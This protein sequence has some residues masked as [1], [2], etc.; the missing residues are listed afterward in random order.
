M[1]E[2][3]KVFEEYHALKALM[4][5]A[6]PAIIS[7]LITLIYNIADTWF[8]GLTNNPGMVAACSLVLPIY[9]LSAAISNL[10]GTGGGSL[11][12]RLLGEKN[13]LEARKVF[14]LSIWLSFLFAVVFACS[15]MLFCDPLLN[16]LGASNQT[17]EYARQYMIYVVGI[18]GIFNVMSMVLSHLIR[19]MGY[20]KEAGIGISM[21]GILNIVLDPIFMFLIFPDGMQVTGA[22]FATMLSNILTF[23]Y[24][25]IVCVKIRKK[26]VVS[27]TLRQGLPKRKSVHAIFGV[28]V[29]AGISVLLFDLASMVANKFMSI[30]G[31]TALAAYGI[32]TKVE[33]LPLNIGI[34]ICLGMI[35]LI[36]YN[37][38]AKNVRRMK[39]IFNCARIVG[40]TIAVLCIILYF[41]C[42]NAIMTFFIGDA[43]T[44]QLGTSFLRAR[45]FA[46]P[47]MF[48]CFNMVHYFNAIGEGRIS[49]GLAVVRQLIFNIPIML[50]LNH[51]YGAYGL[52]WTQLIADLLT[53]IVSYIVYFRKK[54]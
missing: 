48:L 16:L 41:F 52:V 18:G 42:S 28:G 54:I 36:A 27:I 12:S 44:I 6:A 47:F 26:T 21:G 31:D 19:S 53:V 29:P 51:M 9:M 37:Y 10:F 11:I 50:F 1:N 35:P 25:V 34:G 22:A 30:H 13:E 45:C 33:R 4:V 39:Q 20:S 49:F 24:F 3:K 17:S 14:A 8:I 43:E 15:T 5:M 40:V 46:T 23:I 7:Q 2:K 38:S 32:V